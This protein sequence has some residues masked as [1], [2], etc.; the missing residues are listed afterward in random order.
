MTVL[1]I[2]V[3]FII[4]FF[5][6]TRFGRTGEDTL[7]ALG[8]RRTA[9]F[10]VHYLVPALTVVE[11]LTAADRHGLTLADAVLWLL[12][13]LCYLAF[14]TQ[15]ASAGAEIGATGR[16]WPYPFMD[17]QRLG[18][19]RWMGNMLLI[20]AGFFALGLFLLGVSRLI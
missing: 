17:L 5:V 14:C 1:C 4:Y 16:L 6:L 13:P 11:W 2:L 15:R 9:N 18:L 8:V 20:L 10:F 19:R 12:I 7:R 3:T